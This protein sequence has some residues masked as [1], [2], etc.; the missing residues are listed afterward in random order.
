MF[1]PVPMCRILGW[2]LTVFQQRYRPRNRHW[3]SIRYSQL[4]KINLQLRKAKTCTCY[5]SCQHLKLE[6][7]ENYESMRGS[8]ELY[9]RPTNFKKMVYWVF[10]NQTCKMFDVYYEW[11]GTV[12]NLDSPGEE[13]FPTKKKPKKIGMKWVFIY[14]YTYTKRIWLECEWK[15]F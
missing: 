10:F 13:R 1:M 2:G 8:I 4:T 7:A 5:F 15:L 11:K 9:V 12:W 6:D 3:N 14:A